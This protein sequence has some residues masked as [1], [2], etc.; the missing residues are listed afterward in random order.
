[1]SPPIADES[2]KNR[3]TIDK[4]GSVDVR[5]EL[6]LVHF[7]R[8][9]I[10]FPPMCGDDDSTPSFI[11]LSRNTSEAANNKDRIRFIWITQIKY[12]DTSNICYALYSTVDIP[13]EKLDLFL[14]SC[15][16]RLECASQEK[17]IVPKP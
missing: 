16:F 17:T 7:I 5:I 4:Y 15:H 12:L 8:H 1:M 14:V 13:V 3:P 6:C 10:F 9:G 11:V 2:A